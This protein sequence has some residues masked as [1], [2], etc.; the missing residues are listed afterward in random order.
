M[1]A[2]THNMQYVYSNAGYTDSFVDLSFMGLESGL[3]CA[4]P[5]E[6]GTWYITDKQYCDD[7]D[8]YIDRY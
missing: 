4:Y 3:W 7:N 8:W 6:G 5:N 2:A 1:C